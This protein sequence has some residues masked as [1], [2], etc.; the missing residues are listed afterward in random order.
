M[1][2]LGEYLRVI[3]KNQKRNNEYEIINERSNDS[4]MISEK[5]IDN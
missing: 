5:N 4:I 2:I 1:S 3:L